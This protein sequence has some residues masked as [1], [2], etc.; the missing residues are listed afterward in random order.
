MMVAGREGD[1][2]GGRK[3]SEG[4]KVK[5]NAVSISGFYVY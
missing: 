1:R 2:E 4:G 5:Y 3:G